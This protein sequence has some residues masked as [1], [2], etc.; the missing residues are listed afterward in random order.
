MQT[1]KSLA[2][3]S[4]EYIIL[5]LLASEALKIKSSYKDGIGKATTLR[6]IGTIVFKESDIEIKLYMSRRGP[7]RLNELNWS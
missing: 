1:F 7:K 3:D 5:S 4:S 6:N 2:T